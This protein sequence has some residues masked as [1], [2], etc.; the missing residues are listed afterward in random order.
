MWGKNMC[1]HA[2]IVLGQCG[3]GGQVSGIHGLPRGWGAA[4]GVWVS[5]SVACKL[6][7]WTN[8]DLAHPTPSSPALTSSQSEHKN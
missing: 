4:I 5:R 1:K 3:V 8:T 2:Q 7:S 6:L